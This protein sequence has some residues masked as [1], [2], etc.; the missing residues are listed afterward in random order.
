MCCFQ[1]T[2]VAWGRWTYAGSG[3]RGHQ[4]RFWPFLSILSYGFIAVGNFICTEMQ[5][6]MAESWEKYVQLNLFIL[7]FRIK[8]YRCSKFFH[9]DFWGRCIFWFKNKQSSQI[10]LCSKPQFLRVQL[11]SMK[12][13]G[14]ASEMKQTPSPTGVAE[15]VW[16]TSPDFW[17]LASW[18]PNFC[19]D[20]WQQVV[21]SNMKTLYFIY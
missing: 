2:V 11:I 20:L 7:G 6:A 10:Y 1:K 4:D 12:P 21:A 14:L 18:E 17:P 5:G 15:E 3:G 9:F 13:G 8:L 19:F 16:V